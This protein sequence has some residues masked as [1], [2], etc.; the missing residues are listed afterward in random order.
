MVNRRSLALAPSDAWS[1]ELRRRVTEATPI[2][3][4]RRAKLSRTSVWYAVSKGQRRASLATLVKIVD[5]LNRMDPD[6][7][8]AP[9][10]LVVDGPGSD[11]W[12]LAVRR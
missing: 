3:V 8:M 10:Y 4:A 11:T 6:R 5:A 9:P 2:A 7:P 1:A 12:K